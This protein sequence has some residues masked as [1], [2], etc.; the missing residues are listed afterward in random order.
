MILLAGTATRNQT[1]LPLG[2]DLT[3][4]SSESRVTIWRPRPWSSFGPGCWTSGTPLPPSA[5]S[6]V[7]ASGDWSTQR[8]NPPGLYRNALVASSDTNSRTVLTTSGEV[9]DSTSSTN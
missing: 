8:S 2:D 1:V 5:I 7:I 9:P 6:T 3:P 4:Q